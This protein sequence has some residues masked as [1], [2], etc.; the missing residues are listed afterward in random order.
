MASHHSAK[1]VSSLSK[2]VSQLLQ[3]SKG[4][5]SFPKQRALTMLQCSSAGKGIVEVKNVFPLSSCLT[6]LFKLD[7]FDDDLTSI[8]KIDFNGSD[9]IMKSIS[10]FFL[11]CAPLSDQELR[12]TVSLIFLLRSAN[13]SFWKKLHS[14]SHPVNLIASPLGS[15][16]GLLTTAYKS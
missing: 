9:K 3:A 15:S 1:S 14:C 16:F 7:E 11:P 5:T 12:T 6:P 8:W 4:S 2:K 10:R 13:C